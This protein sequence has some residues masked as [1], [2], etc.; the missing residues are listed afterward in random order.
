MFGIGIAQRVMSAIARWHMAEDITICISKSEHPSARSDHSACF[1]SC[2]LVINCMQ[3]MIILGA[4]SGT[5]KYQADGQLLKDRSYTRQPFSRLHLT[6]TIPFL[7]SSKGYF[8][9]RHTIPSFHK[10]TNIDFNRV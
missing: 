6:H 3:P 7:S 2:N 10:V 4:S 1:Q 9:P 8:V 5:R